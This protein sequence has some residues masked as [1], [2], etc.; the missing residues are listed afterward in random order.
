MCGINVFYFCINKININFRTYYN[1]AKPE[2]LQMR[3]YNAIP[4]LLCVARFERLWH[5]AIIVDRI[6]RN[7]T[8][9]VS[10]V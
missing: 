8:V 5:R 1:N 4:G 10:F 3:K 6:K 2:T 9:K 7:Q